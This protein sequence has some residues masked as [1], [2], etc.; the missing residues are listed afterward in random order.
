MIEI[1]WQTENVRYVRNGDLSRVFTVLILAFSNLYLRV[2]EK[3][4]WKYVTD[5]NY[6]QLYLKKIT[7]Y[8]KITIFYIV[9]LKT[10]YPSTKTEAFC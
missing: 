4:L 3:N 9:F 6:P 2:S 5:L 8:Q 7:M 10:D 1:I